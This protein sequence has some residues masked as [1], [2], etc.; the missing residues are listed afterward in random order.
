VKRSKATIVTVVSVQAVTK[1]SD[2]HV[3]HPFYY[4]LVYSPLIVCMIG[5]LLHC[6]NKCLDPS[7]V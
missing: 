6:F 3:P 2:T 1:A 7:S 4:A 5:V